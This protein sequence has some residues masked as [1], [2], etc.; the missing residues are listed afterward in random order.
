MQSNNKIKAYFFLLAPLFFFGLWSYILGQDRNSDLINYHLY[1]AFA[2]IQNKSNDFG[3]AGLQGFF[4]PLI[5]LPY[6]YLINNLKPEAVSF[7]MGTIHGS[8]FIILYKISKKIIA[9]DTHKKINITLIA[10]LGCLT[11]NFL[12]GLG[13]SMGDNLTAILNLTAVLLILIF[14]ERGKQI[15]LYGAALILGFSVGIKLTNAAYA[16]A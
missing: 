14:R 5:D 4:N 12:A 10:F 11:P 7:I 8:I 9:E 15:Y 6:Y 13:N 16:A 2:F 3:V 1:N